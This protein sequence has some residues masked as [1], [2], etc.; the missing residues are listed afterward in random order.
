M[1]EKTRIREG[2]WKL[3]KYSYKVLPVVHEIKNKDLRK[4]VG[5]TRQTIVDYMLSLYGKKW[6]ENLQTLEGD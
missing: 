3:W 4:V 2:L 5:R 6:R 1:R